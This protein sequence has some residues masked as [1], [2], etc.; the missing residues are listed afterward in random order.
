V[1]DDRL[2]KNIIKVLIVF[3]LAFLLLVGYLSYFEVQ[4][5]ERMVVNQYNMR[6]KDKE[7]EVLRGS[8][9]DREMNVIVDSQRLDDNTQKRIYKEGYEMA[10]APVVGYTGKHGKSG[11]EQQYNGSF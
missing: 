4:D 6:N 9:L 10:Y 5:G 1:T 8:I 7:N 11:L 3:S 2:R